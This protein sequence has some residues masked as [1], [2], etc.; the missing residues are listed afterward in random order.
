MSLVSL[1]SNYGSPII[2]SDRAF[3]KTGE[4]KPTYVPTINKEID[5]SRFDQKS[6][7]YSFGMKT[8]IVQ[9]IL[10]VGFSGV[11]AD[12]KEAYSNIHDYFIHRPVNA[13]TLKDFFSEYNFH[14]Y[15]ES[16]FIFILGRPDIDKNYVE[17]TRFGNWSFR[18]NASY[19]E[20][21]STGTGAEAWDNKF[22][23]QAPYLDNNKIFISECI[24]KVLITCIQ[25]INREKKSP[26]NL[27]EGWGGGFDIV[28]YHD[29][30]FHR[31]NDIAYAFWRVDINMPEQLHF[32]SFIHDSY[33]TKHLII[34]NFSLKEHQTYQ[35]TELIENQ[36][37]NNPSSMIISSK[38]V[39]SLIELWDDQQNLGNIAI[40]YQS[41][42]DE[43]L[44]KT[45]DDNGNLSIA[46]NEEY[47]KQ[48]EKFVL[49]NI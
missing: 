7:I 16:S 25:F 36:T 33:N 35:L 10:C 26:D 3:S 9:N 27:L 15:K 22:A 4:L 12:L 43:P 37:E 49:D 6:G 20:L 30:K 13:K 41:P 19:Q 47:N 48:L 28:Y 1:I 32:R 29:D 31:L 17:V 46:F 21:L 45:R 34:R 5:F 8:T 38:R 44:F 2:V 14:E 24:Q 40:A 23:S 39:I 42:S 11:V 18:E